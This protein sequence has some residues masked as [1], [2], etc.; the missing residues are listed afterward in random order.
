MSKTELINL[1]LIILKFSF[2]VLSLVIESKNI[3]AIISKLLFK[4]SYNKHVK[5]SIRHKKK[6]D[7]EK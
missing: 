1:V 6:K 3:T 2:Q 5:K 7:L 4:K